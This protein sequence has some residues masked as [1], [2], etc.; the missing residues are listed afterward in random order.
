MG[1]PYLTLAA[2]GL[3]SSAL[4]L[5]LGYPQ[6][7]VATVAVVPLILFNRWFV[8]GYVQRVETE[9]LRGAVL[10]VQLRTLV[11]IIALLIGYS[12]S[13]EAMFG[14]LLGLNTEVLTYLGG[15]VRSLLRGR[16]A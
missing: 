10:R 15:A 13:V 8:A 2:T 12:V 3:V 14:V 7:A 5:L 11:G 9:N 16:G 4:V 6:A 1:R